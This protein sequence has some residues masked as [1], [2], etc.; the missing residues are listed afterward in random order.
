MFFVHKKVKIKAM[1][2]IEQLLTRGV[3]EVIEREHLEKR[4]RAGEKLRIKHG[5]DPTAPDLHLGHA[6]VLR[7]LREFQD[8]GHKIIFIIGDFTARV[9][10]PSGRSATRPVLSEKEIAKNAKTYFKQAGE[11]LNLKKTEINY[12]G[13]WFNPPTGGGGWKDVLEVAGK[14]TIQRILERDDF[15]KRIKSG[16][17]ITIK[18][19]LY[20]LMQAYD[21]VKIKA[22]VEVG[23][24]DQK[25]NML[26]GRALQR[27]MGA[28]EQDV[29][30]LPI[31]IGLDGEQKMSK[32]LGN[33]IGIAEGPDQMFGKTMSISDNLISNWAELTTNVADEI[34]AIKNPRDAKMKLAYEIVKIYHGEKEA[35]R[36]QE[37]FVKMFQK[38]EAPDEMQEIKIKKGD[39]LGDVLVENKIIS[40]K[41]EFRRLVKNKAIDVD[42]RA[43]EN[44]DY[45]V[46][47][48]TV[49][50]VGKKKFIRIAV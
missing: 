30:T 15:E 46:E 4:L 6:V 27:R 1:D 42:G 37:N 31:L 8:L 43:I 41:S 5:A 39:L 19:I 20:P 23:G 17:E 16:T 35:G 7:K 36:A 50:K 33:Y 48:T 18:E 47:K 11:I 49:V 40:S 9:G 22:D 13:E 12:N 14:F 24:T 34:K 10:D 2:E 21:S 3:E 25:F 26:A 45:V 28:G 32:S 38:R 29:I 44:I